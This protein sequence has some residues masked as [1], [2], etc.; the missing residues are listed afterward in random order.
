M[1]RD[2]RIWGVENGCDNLGVMLFIHFLLLLMIDVN[3]I[4][5]LTWVVISIKQTQP[6]VMTATQ[7][8]D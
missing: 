3:S 4:S 8:L 1:D 2:G 7:L 6:K 5:D